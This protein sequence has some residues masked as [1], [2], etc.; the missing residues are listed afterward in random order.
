M[1]LENLS[2]QHFTDEE[3]ENA[4][5]SLNTIEASLQE[6][7]KNLLPYERVRYG[8]V[9][10]QNK[11]FINKVSDFW[12]NQPELSSPDVDWEEYQKDVA[13]RHFL[14]TYIA[15]LESLVQSLK[16]N[17]ILHDYDCYKAALTDYDYCKY[18]LG[19][20]NSG[21]ETKAKELAQF[22]NKAPYNTAKN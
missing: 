4:I 2:A 11:L 20:K 6:K 21:Y 22:F 3:R 12:K 10:E 16:N 19:T 9:K 18:K 1:P 13:S 8:H 5:V 17:K 14:Q 7:L 15:R